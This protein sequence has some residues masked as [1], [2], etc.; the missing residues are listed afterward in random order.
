MAWATYSPT[1]EVFSDFTRAGVGLFTFS[2]TPTEAGYGLSKTVWVGPG[3]FDY[4]EFDRRVQM[5]LEANPR[6]YF[7]PRLY[8]HAPAWWSAQH[9]DDIVLL[10]PGDGRPV[11]L[12][13]A[14]GKPAPSWASEAWR[15]D[16]VEGLRRLFEHVAASPTPIASSG[17]TSPLA[18]RR[19][20]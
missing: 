8:L 14:G 1:V 16:T 4:S 20:G 18:R 11:P 2:G 15:H 3:E 6:A 10:D 13:H 5:L 19:S 12:V 9:P 17:I 7:F